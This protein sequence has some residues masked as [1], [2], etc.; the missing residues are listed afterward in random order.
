VFSG[1][2]IAAIVCGFWP[3]L[4][5]SEW[6]EKQNKPAL[7]RAALWIGLIC[8]VYCIVT[9]VFLAAGW[10]APFADGSG[11]GI[12]LAHA[13]AD[14]LNAFI[15]R[16]WPYIVIVIYGFVACKI[17]IKLMRTRPTES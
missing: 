15:L 13:P 9:G 17:T 12:M 11:L 7:F 1:W 14:R 4:V 3:C 8:S 16:V 2:V 5:I 6:L 10:K